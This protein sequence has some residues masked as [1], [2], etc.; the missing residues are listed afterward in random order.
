MVWAIM[1]I[2]SQHH[3][4]V[5]IGKSKSRCRALLDGVPQSLVIVPAT[6]NLYTYD[7]PTTVSRKYIYADDIAMVAV[8]AS[9]WASPVRRSRQIEKLLLQLPAKV[10][11]N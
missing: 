11:Y 1:S 7:I 8:L 5:H 10:E 4:H 6:F 3:F 9:C 2:I